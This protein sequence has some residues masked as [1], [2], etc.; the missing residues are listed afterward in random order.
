MFARWSNGRIQRLAAVLGK[1]VY[2]KK[3]IIF[4]QGSS[5]DHIFFVVDGQ[6]SLARQTDIIRKN[7]WPA[8]PTVREVVMTKQ[9][10]S[11]IVDIVGENDFFGKF[12]GINVIHYHVI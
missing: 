10:K 12:P 4:Q 5:A 9:S 3:Q 7:Q 6:V 2:K 11:F 8:S 1:K